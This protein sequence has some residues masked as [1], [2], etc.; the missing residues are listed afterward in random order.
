MMKGMLGEA[1]TVGL[2]RLLPKDLGYGRHFDC[3]ALG[4]EILILVTDMLEA[5]GRSA[6]C[7]KRMLINASLICFMSVQAHILYS[8]STLE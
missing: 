4:L 2:Y 8:E 5:L 7:V 6:D 1:E 3:L